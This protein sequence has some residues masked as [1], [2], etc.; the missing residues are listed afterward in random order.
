MSNIYRCNF[1]P[2]NKQWLFDIQ[3][4]RHKTGNESPTETRLPSSDIDC[5]MPQI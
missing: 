4:S 5:Q 3:K 1:G 2:K